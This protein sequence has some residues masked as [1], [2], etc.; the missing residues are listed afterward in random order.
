MEPI[1][2]V[3]SFNDAYAELAAV[4][5]T[6]LVHNTEREC[7]IH[8][9]ESSLSEGVTAKVLSIQDRCPNARITV[10]RM[11]DGAFAE[12]ADECYGK[13]TWYPLLVPEILG[14]PDRALV[15]EPDT[16]V[17]R[18]VSELFDMEMGG[19]PVACWRRPVPQNFRGLG[20]SSRFNAG[21]MLFNLKYIRQNDSFE[22]GKLT[23]TVRTLRLRCNL[24][25]TVWGA[26]ED[27]LNH[28]L[29]SGAT[30]HFRPGYNFPP[31]SGWALHAAHTLAGTSFNEISESLSNPA[32]IHF[33][34]TTKP[35]AKPYTG[36]MA[37]LRKWWDCHALSPFADAE[38]DAERLEEIIE[39]RSNMKNSICSF[40]DYWDC[41]LFDDILEAVE[42]LKCFQAKGTKIVF[43]GAGF[44]GTILWRAARS[45]GLSPDM[46]CDLN[47]RGAT[48]DGQ[49]IESPEVMRNLDGGA[50]VVIAILEP[51]TLI[52]A[53]NTLL[54][55]GL[56]ENRILP[57]CEHLALGGRRWGEILGSLLPDGQ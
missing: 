36:L 34:M 15:L 7:D 18:D 12:V 40:Q 53:K 38:R 39:C 17:C 16:L 9:F 28:I 45:M 1:V 37:P 33:A 51:K 25:N 31:N 21:V 41:L 5:I 11:L 23:D 50:I 29:D 22:M 49:P 2:T 10:H 47:K 14:G 57:L 52:E 13:E 54:D 56:P 30:A 32:I 48:A 4:S 43:Y 46:V 42:R 35:N 27:Y 20:K 6:S 3:Y 26:R 8:I 19:S 55:L 44:M 24:D